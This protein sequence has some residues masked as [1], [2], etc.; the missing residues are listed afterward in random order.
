MNH[1]ILGAGPAGVVAAETLRKLDARAKITLL[2]DEPEPPYSRMAIPYLLSAN[3]AEQGTHLRKTKGYFKARKIDV[4]VDRAKAVDVKKKEVRLAS[5]AS[6]PYDKLLVATGSRPLTPPIKGI[7]LP[8][9]TGCWTLED[10]RMIMK[11]IQ[12]GA[13]VVLIGAGFI[14]CIILEA[15]VSA[16]AKLTVIEMGDRMVPRMLDAT[17]GRLLQ[18]WCEAKGVKVLTKAAVSAI[19]KDGE[20][21]MVEMGK[22]VTVPADLVISATGVRANSE[23]LEGSGV[24][25]EQDAVRVDEYMASSVADIFAAGDVACGKDFSSGDYSVQAIQPTAV[26]HARVAAHNMHEAGSVRHIGAVPMNV[27]DTIGLIS[28]SYGM[29]QGVEEG[30]E[31]SELLDE[32]GYRYVNLRF[33]GERLVGANT[34]GLTQHIGIVRGLIQGRFKLGEWKARL[35][36]NPLQLMEAYLAVTQG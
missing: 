9:V 24:K 1:L 17:C 19:V 5:G 8:G 16:G 25:I 35:M 14:G 18:K 4:L 2:G 23:F 33:A 30:G 20:R 7:D 34:L 10:A 27:L 36:E 22:G 26:E 12:P 11:T 6:R 29:W 32:E 31:T 15:L 21:Y 13:D 28:A 3:I